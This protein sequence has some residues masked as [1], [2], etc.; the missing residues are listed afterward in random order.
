MSHWSVF[1]KYFNLRQWIVDKKSKN[2]L[3]FL[4]LFLV[5]TDMLEAE[6]PFE[7]KVS[8]INYNESIT[9]HFFC[10]LSHR[11]EKYRI[12]N[13]IF[14]WL[15]GDNRIQMVKIEILT[16]YPDRLALPNK[17]FLID[18]FSLQYFLTSH[19]FKSQLVEVSTQ[20]AEN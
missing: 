13:K 3:K 16:K 5:V 6:S 8:T 12:F 20:S 10:N 2:T 1:F 19:L 14:I 7:S 9:I 15:R 18:S 17:R 4:S 11:N